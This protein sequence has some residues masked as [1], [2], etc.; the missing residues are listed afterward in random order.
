MGVG[1]AKCLGG[2]GRS[3]DIAQIPLLHLVSKE[4]FGEGRGGSAILV[5]VPFEKTCRIMG[6]I[7]EK[8][9]KITGIY[10]NICNIEIFGQ[11]T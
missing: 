8:Y 5:L 10:R 9:C 3:R 11:K 2:G 6:I 1:D 4:I 7:L